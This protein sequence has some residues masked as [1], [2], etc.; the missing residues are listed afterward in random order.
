M[1]FPLLPVVSLIA[2]H[3]GP[4]DHFA[5]Y[6]NDLKKEYDVQVYTTDNFTQKFEEQGIKIHYVFSLKDLSSEEEDKLAEKIAKACSKASVIMTD[7]GHLFDIKVQKA[8]ATHVSKIRRLAY[9]DNPEPFVPGGYSSVAAEVMKYAHGILF[10]NATLTNATIYSEV[11]K[12]VDFGNKERVGIGYY[13]VQQA[14]KIGKRR[15]LEH[16]S[17][18]TEFLEKHG[19]KDNGQKI[20]VY[21]GGNNEVYFSEAFPA[22]LSFLPF[23]SEQVDLTDVVIIIQ[24]HPGAKEKNLDGKQVSTWLDT[25]GNEKGMP[26]IVISDFLS[27]KAQIIGDV[28]LYYQTSMGPLF[29]LAGIP[30]IQIGHEV[31]EDILVRNELAPTVTNAIQFA[32]VINNE[33]GMKKNLS[34]ELILKGLG[35]KEDWLET[36]QS[37]LIPDYFSN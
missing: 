8:L 20:W 16:D 33:E 34:K 25:Y 26:T 3:G 17:M 9:Y 30:T 14:E 22:F 10:A 37:A 19:I 31:Y 13:P 23:L 27:D 15:Q 32:K 5:I 12:K 24:Q 18:R 28:A 1:T 35:I 7:V 6:A 36:L 11:E 21:F 2:C 29:V 4:A